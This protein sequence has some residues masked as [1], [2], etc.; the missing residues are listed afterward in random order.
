MRRRWLIGLAGLVLVWLALVLGWIWQ[1]ADSAPDARADI[2]L[3][4]GAAVDDDEPSPVFAARIDH[5]I[6]LWNEGRVKRILFTGGR[7]QGDRLG[8]AQAARLRA[9]AAGVPDTAILTEEASRTTME[10]LVFA[11]PGNLGHTG[12]SVLLVTDPLHMRRALTMARDLGYD[13]QPEPT[14]LTRYRS[15]AAKV[16]FALRELWLIHLYWLIGE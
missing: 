13:A 7:A 3:V 9:V 10:N 12:G 15:L 8:E 14:P 2:A 1:G 4:L 16:P 11:Q 6:A 5:A